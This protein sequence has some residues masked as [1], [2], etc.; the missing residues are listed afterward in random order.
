MN[1][2]VITNQ[3]AQ[4]L[5]N[6]SPANQAKLLGS[7]IKYLLDTVMA[8]MG[9][10]FYLDPANGND[11]NDGQSVS[12]AV[13]TLPIGYG[14]LR[15][16]Y[17]DTLVYI[18]GTGSVSLSAKLTWSKSYAHLIGMAAPVVVG[19]R[20]RI[21]QAA[22]ATGVSPLIDITGS[23]CV[24]KNI[25]VNHGVNDAT[26][27][28]AV[29]VT[30]QRN[31]FEN[32]HFTGIN[33]ATQDVSGASSLNLSGAAE[34]L[35]VNC[36]IGSDTQTTRGAN[37]T[38]LAIDTAATRNRFVNCTIYAYISNA[39]HALV[40]VGAL[41]IDRWMIFDN[42]MFITDSLNQAVT[43]TQ[44]FSLPAMTQGKVVMKDCSLITDGASG[45]GAW[46]SSG[47]G[48]IWNNVPAPAAT[49]GGGFSTKR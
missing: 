34:N 13:K 2:N 23:G 5:D 25:Y 49:A 3:E 10:V 27:K 45:S 19:G 26:S 39:G 43:L 4:L 42:C 48:L 15:D 32:C 11:A 40:T 6:A 18:A 31:Y 20:A 8:G 44:V 30:G 28:I 35:F 14:L 47:R 17:N 9:N 7:R 38:E 16:G 21:F 12:T 36:F 24:F 1:L 22:A 46:D 37:S 41:G 29:R 33:N